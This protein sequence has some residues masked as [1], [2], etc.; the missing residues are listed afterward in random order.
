M[1]ISVFNR[2]AARLRL[3]ALVLVLFVFGIA[4][5]GFAADAE[6]PFSIYYQ[7][8]E[9]LILHRLEL[10]PS[11]RTVATLTDTQAA[12][13]QDQ[14]PPPGPELNALK[15]RVSEGMG[16]VVILGADVDPASL[17]ALTDG[18]IE[19]TGVVDAPP[20]PNHAMA[21]EQLAAIISYLGPVDDPIGTNVSW[22]SAV[23]I[24][25]RSLLKVSPGAT[26]MVAT[27]SADPIR[28]ATPILMRTRLGKGAIYILNVWIKQGDL[29]ERERSYLRMLQGAHG[30]QNYDFQRFFFF[31]WILYAMTRE[32]AGVA[33]VRFG[34]WIA[35]PVPGPL[36]VSLLMGIFGATLAAIVIGVIWARRYSKQH[37]EEVEHFYRRGAMEPKPASLGAAAMPQE[38]PKVTVA[39]GDPRWEVVG[40]HRPLSGF[41]YN[42]LI[43]IVVLIPFN[44]VVTFWIDRNFINP[45][46]EARGAGQAVAQVMLFL[47]PLLDLGTSQAMIKYYA[48]YRVKEPGR[49]ITYMQFFVWFHLLLGILAVSALGLIGA[50]GLPG[51][52]FAYLSWFVVLNSLAGFPPF[53]TSF[54]SLFRAQQRFDY[55]QLEIVLFYGMNPVLQM[56]GAVLGRHWGL[57]HPVF[58]EGMGVV[59][60]FACGSIVGNVLIGLISCVFYERMGMRLLTI[61]LAHFNR[62]T[63]KKSIVYGLKLTAGS[64]MPF[65][66]WG[67][68]P[69]I[70]GALLPNFLEL[71]EIWLVVYG[72]TF[73]YLE[74]GV[75]IFGS[76]MPSISE[77]YSQNMFKLTQRY[78][79]QGLRWGL[80][81]TMML[82]G[83]YIVFCGPLIEG[84]LP[85]QFSR[86]VG[87]L[88][89]IHIFRFF[90]FFVRGPDQVFQAT[91]RSGTFTLAA[92]IENVAR[93]GM[94]W[95]FIKW[96]GFHGLFWAFTASAALKA[97]F[98][99]PVMARYI[100]APVFSVWQT[101]VNPTLA[102]LA[103]YYILRAIAASL[104]HGPGHTANTWL[105]VMITLLGSL[106]IYMFISAILGWDDAELREFKDAVELVPAPFRILAQLMYAVVNL[107]TSLSPLHNRFGAKLDVEA[108]REAAL[109]TAA[110]VQMH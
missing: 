67:T 70:M 2:G 90:D 97:L 104:W 13:Y 14:L 100:V 65:F 20:G 85:P 41:L 27:T 21:A 52:A 110:K 92:I 45:F 78:I 58:G 91:G 16:L 37:P 80:M 56:T 63:M 81:V 4:G 24:H 101:F 31:N 18:A 7:G 15:A 53:F 23:R 61:M 5:S 19:Q 44:F 49:A 75:A 36:A 48:E 26:V 35:A 55:A 40:F 69:V 73:A 77:S 33:P 30:A 66:T 76:L 106:P 60:G 34:R 86:A 50:I 43:N 64:V 59:M 82:G 3:A 6:A 47:L 83:A 99:W 103:N 84:L 12:V 72:L 88:V 51:T 46:L 102:A 96:W 57:M 89:L 25:E 93:I 38:I 39:H 79:D 109:L 10:D 17:K 108:S 32:S 54:F 1:S 11:T 9:S 29:A 28:P 87:V 94:S 62:D 74:I 68:V 105:V 71:N 42:Y 22:K 98:V 8:R 107:G 95:F